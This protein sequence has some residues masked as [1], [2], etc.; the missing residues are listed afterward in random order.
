MQP[1]YQ[2][3]PLKPDEVQAVVAYLEDADKRG[4]EEAGFPLKFFLFGLGGTVLGLAVVSTLGTSRIWPRGRPLPDGALAAVE[5]PGTALAAARPA[6]SLVGLLPPADRPAPEP[7]PEEEH[8][9]A[10]L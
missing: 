6:R 5:H 2:Q 4:V 1:L 9:G 8:I 3:H 10:G 7:Y